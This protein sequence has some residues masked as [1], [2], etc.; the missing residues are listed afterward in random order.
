[1]SYSTVSSYRRGSSVTGSLIAS[2]H[3][4]DSVESSGF[5]PRSAAAAM[6]M[7]HMTP[8]ITPRRGRRHTDYRHPYETIGI[9]QKMDRLLIMFDDFKKQAERDSREATEN[10]LALQ[11]DIKEIKEKQTA[12]SSKSAYSRKKLPSDISVNHFCTVP[13]CTVLIYLCV[14]LAV[15]KVHDKCEPAALFDGAQP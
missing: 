10:L 14:Q 13:F 7:E 5:D 1:M 3:D 8:P 12:A 4:L 6:S 11:G 9:D 15:K 2:D